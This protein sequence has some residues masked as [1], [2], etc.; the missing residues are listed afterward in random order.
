MD[1]VQPKEAN[2]VAITALLVLQLQ[3]TT[4]LLASACKTNK[5]FTETW[6]HCHSWAALSL[7]KKLAIILLTIISCGIFLLVALIYYAINRDNPKS[8]IGLFREATNFRTQTTA[9]QL[10]PNGTTATAELPTSTEQSQQSESSS[11]PSP[12]TVVQQTPPQQPPPPQTTPQPPQQS[13]QTTPQ[14]PQQSPQPTQPAQVALEMPQCLK[15]FL[16]KNTE[17]KL[18]DLPIDDAAANDWSSFLIEDTS[19]D[20]IVLY[21]DEDK[22]LAGMKYFSDL[23]IGGSA[24][25]SIDTRLG[26]LIFLYETPYPIED[27]SFRPSV[28]TEE[29]RKITIRDT[30]NSLFFDPIDGFTGLHA[31]CAKEVAELR[32]TNPGKLLTEL[33]DLSKCTTV[34]IGGRQHN[35][36][37]GLYGIADRGSALRAVVCA[38]AYEEMLKHEV[39]SAM[40]Y[41]SSTNR[42]VRHHFTFCR[43]TTL[44]C[45]DEFGL[46]KYCANGSP[47][48]RA[49]VIETMLCERNYYSHILASPMHYCPKLLDG[50]TLDHAVSVVMGAAA[51][52][53][54]EHRIAKYKDLFDEDSCIAKFIE[55][56]GDLLLPEKDPHEVDANFANLWD[57]VT[58]DSDRRPHFDAPKAHQIFR[59]LFEEY[60]KTKS[61][62]TQ[63]K[64]TFVAYFY[65]NRPKSV[66]EMFGQELS[67]IMLDLLAGQYRSQEGYVMVYT[68]HSICAHVDLPEHSRDIA[69]IQRNDPGRFIE[70]TN[71]A[72]ANCDVEIK[73]EGCPPLSITSMPGKQF[74]VG[75][76]SAADFI[77]SSRKNK[78]MCRD[79]KMFAA[80]FFLGA[81]KITQ[82]IGADAIA[83][84]C[85]DKNGFPKYVR[86]SGAVEDLT[87]ERLCE[88]LRDAIDTAKWVRGNND[89]CFRAISVVRDEAR[90]IW[91]NFTICKDDGPAP[92]KPNAARPPD[93]PQPAPVELDT[94]Q[95]IAAFLKRNPRV[96]L[97]E[98]PI[99]AKSATD[100]GTFFNGNYMDDL[101]PN[102]GEILMGIKYFSTAP[103]EGDGARDAKIRIM[104]LIFFFENAHKSAA[105]VFGR[106]IFH[107]SSS[108]TAKDVLRGIV[109]SLLFGK[110]DKFVGDYERYAEAV[111]ALRHTDPGKLFE[112]LRSTMDDKRTFSIAGGI[113]FKATL[114]CAKP[115]DSNDAL[116]TIICADAYAEMLSKSEVFRALYSLPSSPHHAPSI[117]VDSKSLQSLDE[118][119]LPKY[120]SINAGHGWW[121]SEIIQQT[122]AGLELG[123]N[124]SSATAII[125]KAA[126][127]KWPDCALGNY[128]G[129]FSGY[130]YVEQFIEWNPD[131]QLPPSSIYRSTH[132]A[133]CFSR[134]ADQTEVSV[135][136]ILGAF[137]R[138][139]DGY[140]DCKT[141][142]GM[143]CLIIALFIYRNR[144][145]PHAKLFGDAIFKA[146]NDRGF[147]RLEI[148]CWLFGDPY[149]W[150]LPEAD[151]IVLMHTRPEEFIKAVN[152]ALN[153]KC[154]IEI[155]LEGIAP[156]TV[157]STLEKPLSCRSALKFIADSEANKKMCSESEVF[158]A[159]YFLGVNKIA[160][161]AIKLDGDTMQQLDEEGFPKYIV[162]HC[163]QEK[164]T[165]ESFAEL[166]NDAAVWACMPDGKQECKVAISILAKAAKKRWSD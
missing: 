1:S 13:P 137:H 131:L 143:R 22:I 102:K 50:K 128:Q 159:L 154:T 122:F 20:P 52:K 51:K 100:W 21:V 66:E 153:E 146:M 141:D 33:R 41:F 49:K 47:V 133:E 147:S 25:A 68:F 43:T 53:W 101:L 62:E 142:E 55:R 37:Y 71:L 46:P 112:K 93:P 124:T 110:T 3:V 99:D 64:L 89:D 149:G 38:R 98:Q 150:E 24:D 155:N 118:F 152:E 160:T 60:G 88:I 96:R 48:T 81:K 9:N 104:A 120:L 109:Y 165:A 42:G 58:L 70:M 92:Q 94:S 40:V 151:M 59:C 34:T 113:T 18:P 144:N 4:E 78:E 10:E 29:D 74:N 45:L 23:S 32:S 61:A 2:V 125:L 6:Q 36:P 8:Q 56:N 95:I 65:E 17:V 11:S 63:N 116:R 164:L 87:V 31:E 15:L 130:G 136:K 158:R 115:I 135:E 103:T 76:S 161:N 139:L 14:Q 127:K 85:L 105:D 19:S 82:G 111:V 86:I 138:F 117:A 162:A 5:N 134:R 73:F 67:L 12:S 57:L 80:L 145:I 69:Q 140:R 108:R 79:S 97:P 106:E 72:L 27:Y 107:V 28:S 121:C 7:G 39:F 148:I 75:S 77:S 119:G 129:L 157:P 16:A 163:R 84:Q 156:V 44:Q 114:S 126:R 132:L 123:P 30:I 54:P 166:L 91:P 26:I 35:I 90:K 83:Q